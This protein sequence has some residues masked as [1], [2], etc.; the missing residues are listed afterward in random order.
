MNYTDSPAQFAER[1]DPW[2]VGEPT[3]PVVPGLWFGRH[4]DASVEQATQAVQE[5]IEI[6]REKTGNFCVFAYSS[7]FDSVDQELARQNEKQKSTR[8]IRREILL[9]YLNSLVEED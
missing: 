5:Q 3:V 7:L 6:A 4:P 8:E 1:I 2:L 9:P